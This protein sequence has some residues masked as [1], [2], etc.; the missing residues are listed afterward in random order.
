MEKRAIILVPGFAKREQ[1][2]ARDQLVASLDHY[3]EGYETVVHE[4]AGVISGFNAATVQAKARKSDYAVELHVYEAYWGDLVPDWSQEMP[5]SRFL[6]GTKLIVYWAF[7]GLWKSLLRRELPSRTA[8]SL[9]IASLILLFWYF[10]V[11]SLVFAA[12]SENASAIPPFVLDFLNWCKTVLESMGL[13]PIAWAMRFQTFL[14]WT[15]ILFIIGFLT[16]GRMESLANAADY[17]KGYLRDDPFDGG[18]IGPQAK[19]R[20]RVVDALDYVYDCVDQDGTSTYDQVYV[21]AHSLGGSIAVDALSEYGTRLKTTTLFTWGSAMGA[22]VQQEPLV[23]QEIAKFYC[24]EPRIKN[25]VDVVLNSDMLASRVPIPK[26]PDERN[27]LKPCTPIFP[28]P[29]VPP[30]PQGFGFRFGEIHNSYYRS[31]IAI[32][33]LIAPSE[34]LP[35]R[36]PEP[37]EDTD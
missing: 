12:V 14:T 4:G 18:L 9:I 37:V 15:P 26:K 20:K 2:S 16:V 11:I 8:I 34:E 22:L 31:E 19:S 25:W 32:Q 36:E 28:D 30:F 27:R 10:T 3:S 33:M 1:L 21:V 5:V 6:R 23:E 13:D 29:V 17:L 35:V 7:G 24:S